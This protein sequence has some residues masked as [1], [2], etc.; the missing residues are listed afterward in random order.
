MN[1]SV[2]AIENSVNI[3]VAGLPL[4]A[5]PGTPADAEKRIRRGVCYPFGQGFNPR[6]GTPSMGKNKTFAFGDAAQDPFRIPA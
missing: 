3:L 6:R 4:R 2:A 5:R 1:T